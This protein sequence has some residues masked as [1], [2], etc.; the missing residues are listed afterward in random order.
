MVSNGAQVTWPGGRK[1]AF[2]IFDDTDWA[3]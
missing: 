1:F 2:T 3:T